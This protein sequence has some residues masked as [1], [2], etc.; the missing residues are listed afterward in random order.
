[1]LR[2]KWRFWDPRH[3]SSDFRRG[4]RNGG[5]SVADHLLYGILLLIATPI[6]V[7]YLGVERYGIWMLSNTFVNVGGVVVYGLTDATI[8]FVAQYRAA[9]DQ[10]QLQRVVL[11]SL[12]MYGLLGLGVASLT[13]VAAPFLARHVFHVGAENVELTIHA[14]QIAGIALVLRL[15]E[16][17]FQSVLFGYERYDLAAR[18]TMVLNVLSFAINMILIVMG[19]GLLWL[20]ATTT[21]LL[22]PAIAWK[23]LVV[24]RRLL[25]SLV[26][27]PCFD[28]EVFSRMFGFGIW[29]WLQGIG[30]LF[31]HQVDRLLVASLLSTSAL[32]YYAV[33]MQL[34]QQLHVLSSRAVSF[35]FPLASAVQ[36]S[37]DLDRLRRIYYKGSV[38][39]VVVAVGL[40]APF[41]VLAEQILALWMGSEFAAGSAS[42]FRLQIVFFTALAT[43][44]VPHF[45][46]NGTGLVRL[47]T[48]FGLAS[49]IVVALSGWVLIPLLGVEGAAWAKIANIP[50]ALVSVGILHYRVL[51]DRRWYSVVG[52]L[53][54]V[55]LPLAIVYAL[56]HVAPLPTTGLPALAL[57]AAAYCLVGMLSAA[58]VANLTDNASRWSVATAE[59]R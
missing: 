26:L 22:A 49:G 30:N 3:R 11:F 41:F 8:K 7:S 38:F 10:A 21:V 42:V 28:R 32:A 39:T 25:P 27:A 47:N 50:V 12:T 6:F 52:V 55:F 9:G 31:L 56:A 33:G 19:F 37:G 46:L 29:S 20:L 36:E 1:M 23:A 51:G 18:I 4:M 15:L 2:A 24:K 45:F 17:V 13:A 44:I 53:L 59:L 43:T 54:P 58:L 5:Y 57:A 48:L 16:S 14:L 40:A 35:T 34:A